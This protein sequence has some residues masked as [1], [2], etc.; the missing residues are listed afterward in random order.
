MSAGLLKKANNRPP[1]TSKQMER[2]LKGIA[3]H[4]RIDI[5]LLVSKSRGIT[6]EGIAEAL[7]CNY[8]TLSIHTSKLVQAGLIEKKYKGRSVCN[9]LTPYGIK[10]VAFLTSLQHY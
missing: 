8:T 9:N 4:R 7:N 1:K 2:H 6:V 3:N 10:F 5:L